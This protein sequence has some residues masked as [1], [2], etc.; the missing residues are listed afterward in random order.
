MR[1]GSVV[2]ATARPVSLF[3]SNSYSMLSFSFKEPSCT[4]CFRKAKKA[5]FA[6]KA[7]H[8]QVHVWAQHLRD[9]QH[10]RDAQVS[11]AQAQ[12]KEHQKLC[13]TCHRP[14]YSMSFQQW[15][16]VTKPHVSDLSD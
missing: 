15:C 9:G 3:P 5:L 12:Q 8:K 1:F 7:R 4:S 16:S 10:R 6:V 14:M 2:A 13:P 11:S